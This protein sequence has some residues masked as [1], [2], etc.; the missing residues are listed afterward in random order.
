MPTLFSFRV[1]RQ[2][3]IRKSPACSVVGYEFPGQG[4]ANVTVT[5][6]NATVRYDGLL[7]LAG[8]NGGNGDGDILTF[9]DGEKRVS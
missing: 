2:H 6:L 3:G 7:Q 5:T 8:W 4:D 9:N 1:F